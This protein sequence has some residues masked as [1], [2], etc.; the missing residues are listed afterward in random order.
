MQ[1]WMIRKSL[2]YLKA[3]LEALCSVLAKL[4]YNLVA[5]FTN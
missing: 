2:N 1:F 4:F 3:V 5:D